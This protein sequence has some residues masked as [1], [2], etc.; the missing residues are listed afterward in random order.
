MRKVRKQTRR[1]QE[2]G[3]GEGGRGVGSESRDM[4]EKRRAVEREPRRKA[5]STGE[6]RERERER[7]MQG[8][9]EGRTSQGRK[10]GREKE[11]KENEEYRNEGAEGAGSKK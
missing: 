9:K 4:M 3:G 7:G 11:R 8:C 10:E 5:G 6:T 1:K 2:E